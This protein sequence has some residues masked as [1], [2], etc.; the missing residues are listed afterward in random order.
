[1]GVALAIP[2]DLY[3]IERVRIMRP[4]ARAA[5]WEFRDPGSK[6]EESLLAS[7]RRWISEML[8]KSGEQRRQ[9][10]S[11]ER[12]NALASVP[13][14]SNRMVLATLKPK[15]CADPELTRFC[16]STYHM[17]CVFWDQSAMVCHAALSM[18]AVET[19]SGG[20]PYIYLGDFNIQPDTAG[21]EM[22][23]KGGAFARE[24]ANE[25]NPFVQSVIENP[26]DIKFA[27]NLSPLQSAYATLGGEPEMT[28]HTYSG[29][30]PQMFTGC[31]DYIFLS[32]SD[33]E[34]KW[35][36]ESTLPLPRV[37]DNPAICPNQAEP[38][39]HLLISATLA[40]A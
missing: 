16:V 36:V 30:P 12:E 37:E 33:A 39:D 23:V 13:R 7:W 38:S 25:H 8:G 20:L 17:P 28:N 34:S 1:M 10:R 21:Y 15:K 4:C 14:R 22:L 18:D 5:R 6:A 31:I 9:G 29:D 19:Y 24:P 2:D 32:T 11:Y 35:Q 40:L 27:H 26:E 3:D